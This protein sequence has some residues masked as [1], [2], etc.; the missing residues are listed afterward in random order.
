MVLSPQL[1][2]FTQ[3]SRVSR[4]V[5]TLGHS[6][7]NLRLVGPNQLHHVP[8]IDSVVGCIR[9]SMIRGGTGVFKCG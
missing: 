1:M 6:V 5:T 4:M 7:P 3:S 9:V 8:I 2:L